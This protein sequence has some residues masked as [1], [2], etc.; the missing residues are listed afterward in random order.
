MKQ[1]DKPHPG[2]NYHKLS[3]GGHW[4]GVFIVIACCTLLFAIDTSLPRYFLV[5][6]V[7]L[8]IVIGLLLRR[9]RRDNLVNTHTFLPPETPTNDSTARKFQPQREPADHRDRA[10][11]RKASTSTISSY[12]PKEASLMQRILA[13][14]VLAGVGLSVSLA[15]QPTQLHDVAW[16]LGALDKRVIDD[17]RGITG[18]MKKDED[19]GRYFVAFSLVFGPL[20][21]LILHFSRRERPVDT[22]TLLPL[23]GPR[24]RFH[25]SKL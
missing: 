1:S 13:L 25:S 11:R 19:V 15:P 18:Q 20:I 14:V 24:T 23:E 5:F 10:L 21:G 7:G 6:S 8:G 16:W 9:V 12:G 3:V 2:I 17:L 4:E 22:H